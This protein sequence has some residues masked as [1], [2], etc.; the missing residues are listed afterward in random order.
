M[1]S[2]YNQATLSYNGTTTTSNITTGEIIDV[3]SVT[4]T[5]VLGD[6]TAGDVLTYVVNIVNSGTAP[7]SG[8]TVTDDLGTFP[9][10]N[11]TLTPLTYADGSLRY[12]VNG[13]PQT[14]PAVTAGPP[15]TVTGITVP[16][17]GTA[18]LVY[19]AEVNRFAPL[20]TTGSITN[21]VSVSGSGL[22]APVTAEE[23]V[24]AA[25]TPILAITKSLNPTSVAENGRI[26]YTF[27]VENYGSRAAE[28]T[29]N[30]TITDLFDPILENL[31]VS[32]DGTAWTAPESYTYTADG[33]FT[34]VPGAITVPAASFTRDPATGIV[35]AAPGTAVLTVTGTI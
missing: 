17:G 26:T 16:A 24:S 22:T 25:V 20:D 4:K 3:L 30:V 19:A 1:A 29:D 21:E 32:F 9:E 12:F 33:L 31:A 11:L 5:A 23:T 15:L 2:F 34:T 14:A 28:T 10:G 27:V 6:Y 8:L 35:T 18:A 13:V 7:F